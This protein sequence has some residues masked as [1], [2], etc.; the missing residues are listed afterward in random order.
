M[1]QFTLPEIWKRHAVPFGI[2][3]GSFNIKIS[4]YLGV[5][6]MTVKRIIKESSIVYEGMSAQKL[7]SF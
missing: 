7:G 5:N 1:T 3:E 4:Q 2:L 6:L